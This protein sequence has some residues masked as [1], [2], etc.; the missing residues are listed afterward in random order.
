MIRRDDVKRC[1]VCRG[2]GVYEHRGHRY[3]VRNACQLVAAGMI[4]LRN[5][6]ARLKARP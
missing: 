4:S 1:R 6:R 2:R 5:G 3:C